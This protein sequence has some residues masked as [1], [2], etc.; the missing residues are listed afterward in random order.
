MWKKYKR[1][2]SNGGIILVCI[3][4][5]LLASCQPT[6]D[7]QAVVYGLDLQEKIERSSA[8][9]EV[10]EALQTWT[11]MLDMTK[12]EMDAEVIVPDK[13]VFPLYKVE[14]LR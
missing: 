8:S 6:P 3:I 14:S 12:A 11:E 1:T 13:M 4:V 9:K 5:C 10:Y 7:K 2:N